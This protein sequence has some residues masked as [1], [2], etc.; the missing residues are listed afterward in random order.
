MIKT[1]KDL[2]DAVAIIDEQLRQIQK[3]LGDENHAKSK[4]AFPRGYIRPAS[5]FR[6]HLSFI[7]DTHVRDNLAYALIQ[8]DVYRWLL[9]RTDLFGIAKEMTIKS[10]L[11]LHGAICETMCI[12]ATRG[13]IGKKHSF[14]NRC[15]RMVE[16]G[17]INQD[18][19]YELHWLW[20]TRASI[21]IYELTD[22]EYEKYSVRDYNRSVK[23]TQALREALDA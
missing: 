7:S 14:C 16:K 5:H 4:I 23:A 10:G 2:E 8:S 1:D 18:L 15:D 13:K 9:S 6:D 11:A 20:E 21:H 12:V 22:R 3:Y 19:C 17:I